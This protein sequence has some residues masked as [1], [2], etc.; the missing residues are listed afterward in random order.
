[1]EV[2][3]RLSRQEDFSLLLFLSLRLEK[4]MGSMCVTLQMP[5]VQ[6]MKSPCSI[7]KIHK[8]SYLPVSSHCLLLCSCC[9]LKF[10]GW[11]GSKAD[12]EVF[13]IN[14]YWIKK[15]LT[16]MASNLHLINTQVRNKLQIQTHIWNSNPGLPTKSL[17]FLLSISR[18]RKNRKP[19][20]LEY[21]AS[22]RK[23]W[24]TKGR[25]VWGNMIFPKLIVY[26]FSS[27]HPSCFI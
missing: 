8:A 20:L 11:Y 22:E 3:L 4:I 5:L 9:S 23:W 10:V 17:V 15:K 12:R 26:L 16:L 7:V 24:E 2:L 18:Y 19:R 14:G 6:R 13:L 21:G 27:E 1:M 25:S